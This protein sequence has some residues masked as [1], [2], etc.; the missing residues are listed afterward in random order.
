[1]IL[2]MVDIGDEAEDICD[3]I[4]VVKEVERRKGVRRPRA[5]KREV[6]ELK[7]VERILNI[8]LL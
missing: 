4:D 1:M 6:I 7:R 8:S 2:V 3:D 5:E